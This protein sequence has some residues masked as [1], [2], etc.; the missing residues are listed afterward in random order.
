MR[1][2]RGVLEPQ[3]ANA[4]PRQP[5]IPRCIARDRHIGGMH[6][7]VE[8]DRDPGRRALEVENEWTDRM[9]AAKPDAQSSP[10]QKPPENDLGRRLRA[11]QAVAECQHVEPV[12][13]THERKCRR[14]HRATSVRMCGIERFCRGYANRLT[15]HGIVGARGSL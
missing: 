7:T 10:T 3:H 4:L 13:Q 5:R 11:P 6:G 15:S 2:K 12:V 1:A 9:L 8:L 14:A